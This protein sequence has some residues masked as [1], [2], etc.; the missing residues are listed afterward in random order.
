MS[1]C[2]WGQLQRVS[3]FKYL[4][5]VFD[6]SGTDGNGAECCRKEVNERKVAVA[7]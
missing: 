4:R 1:H 3:E 7:I 5:L 2:K 6:E